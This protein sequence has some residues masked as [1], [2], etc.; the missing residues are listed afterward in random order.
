M[1]G[2]YFPS[3]L[4]DRQS[5]SD[6]LRRLAFEYFATAV[7]SGRLI[8][9]T[10]SYSTGHLGYDSWS[11]MAKGYV[12]QVLAS[13]PDQ[14]DQLVAEIDDPD[15]RFELTDVMDIAE[16]RAK[17]DRHGNKSEFE[18]ARTKLAAN[19]DLKDTGAEHDAKPPITRTL[20]R[21]LRISRFI[22]LN[23]DLEIEWEAFL[24]DREREA[25]H[26]EQRERV[27]AEI[28]KWPPQQRQKRVVSGFGP[29]VSEVL[30]RDNIAE[31]QS[32]ALHDD[33][34]RCR[35]LHLHG[36][37]DIP[38]SMVVSRRDYRDRYQQAGFNRLPFEYAVRTI[39]SGNPILFVGIGMSEPEINIHFERYLSDNP[40]RRSMAM[41]LLWSTSGDKKKDETFRLL[42]NRKLGISV[43][44][45][46]EIVD[47]CGMA[48]QYN[49]RLHGVSGSEERALR[50]QLPLQYLARWCWE[51]DRP[52]DE[53][54]YLRNPQ[55]KYKDPKDRIN[56]WHASDT[57]TWQKPGLSAVPDLAGDIL[58][59]KPRLVIT[60]PP[61]SGRGNWT[62][63]LA[64]SLANA[65]PGKRRLVVINGSFATETDSIFAILSGAFDSRT[66]FEDGKS[67]VKATNQMIRRIL[68]GPKA[69]R[70]ATSQE[71]E[72][73]ILIINGMER[74]IAHDGTAI[75]TELDMLIRVVQAKLRGMGFSK[76]ANR[77]GAL[78]LILIGS[79]R[80]KRYIDQIAPGEFEHLSISR[81]V[82]AVPQPDGTLSHKNVSALKASAAS[83]GDRAI[84][85]QSFFEHLHK[86]L[87][88]PRHL[89]PS[90]SD[91][92]GRR[93]FLEAVAEAVSKERGVLPFEILRAMAFIGQPVEVHVLP[94]VVKF[95]MPSGKL[96][97]P[98]SLAVRKAVTTELAW[99]LERGLIMQIEE[100]P[101]Q[102]P[103]FGLHKALVAEIRERYGVPLSDARLAASFNLALFAAQPVDGVRP[104]REW[105]DE[106][107]RMVDFMCGQ[108]KDK[109]PCPPKLVAV[110]DRIR[111]GS[112]KADLR[113][114]FLDG[115][116]SEEL[117]R[118][119]CA[120]QSDCL[121]AA[122]SLM[123][124]YF[125]TS[126]LLMQTNHDLDT[127][128]RNAPLT[129]H[130]DRL[131]RLI[132]SH[133]CSALLRRLIEQE[134][135]GDPDRDRQDII[136]ALGAA[137]FYADDLCWLYNELGV[138]LVTQG[139][140]GEA[141]QALVVAQSI[142][143]R[144]VEF[145]DRHHNWRRIAFNLVQVS[146][147]QGH[148]NEAEELL[149]EIETALEQ[150]AKI[151]LPEGVL[152]RSDVRSGVWRRDQPE[153]YASL[154]DYVLRKFAERGGGPRY[155]R[156][157]DEHFPANLILGI[158]L[159][160]GYRGLCHHL[161]GALSA[162]EEF[163]DQSVRILDLLGEQRA[164]S[165]FQR[166][167]VSLLRQVNKIEEAREAQKHCVSS[168]G[169]SRQTDIDHAG[170]LALGQLGFFQGRDQEQWR[171]EHML[172]Q[173]KETL[174]YAT[175][176]DMYRL[177]VE[178][179]HLIA[180][181]QLKQ[182]DTDASLA[183]VSDAIAIATR[184]G[185]GLRKIGLRTLLGRILASRNQKD[186][187]RTI[188]EEASLLAIRKGYARGGEV[189]ED[190]LVK[191]DADRVDLPGATARR[192]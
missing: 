185:F 110:M 161:R 142:N 70:D 178:A 150:D 80:L 153:Q 144:L 63:T 67:R 156:A 169:P 13:E 180:F 15:S 120:R 170:R 123:R 112:G 122:L 56:L 175:A 191:L 173:L 91:G 188:L 139:N 44:F 151:V 130:A 104:D 74:F 183:Y 53:K 177:Q 62:E 108:Y 127:W 134:I 152:L 12:R 186:A 10:G 135:A 39:L 158:A 95:A 99:L 16:V 159:V 145:G 190:E 81:E 128:L 43:L 90:F 114:S 1:T 165:I 49:A 28:L 34:S 84:D 72:Q 89:S 133:E 55:A 14:A 50:M 118:L 182:G 21:D 192:D 24:A 172:P 68:A 141:R 26:H 31:L 167:R 79:P 129:D 136:Q 25:N 86:Q 6:R 174:R 162:A 164:F 160:L 45:D 97:E 69:P 19:F 59:L 155:T 132:R 168:A 3:Y 18:T 113:A 46:D 29:V 38:E 148:I 35:I 83:F 57:S 125:S 61:G 20:L 4:L 96:A 64:R 100:F 40:N 78:T 77:E 23:Y 179:L 93:V 30:G 157:V 87:N 5:N 7:H 111:A 184:Y 106:L 66:A 140:L 119:A 52:Q 88:L 8:A 176:S 27:F 181:Q 143:E 98:G 2:G 85:G 103:R 109:A 33:G 65:D 92:G 37:A 187:A 189:A 11:A 22:T 126:S 121:R 102:A 124:S 48:D 41:F 163:L 17:I 73:L 105:H 36:R 76:E 171:G 47:F 166:H 60:G 82:I 42:Y 51:S 149:R 131:R 115:L 9:F 94:H 138:V 71:V 58:A 116:A 137:A 54:A 117:A 101:Q 32:F 147:D 75:S 146:I 154:R 107:A